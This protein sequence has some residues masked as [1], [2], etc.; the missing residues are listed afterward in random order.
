L[1]KANIKL[2]TEFL[3]DPEIEVDPS[4]LKQVLI[5]LVQNAAESIGRDGSI[6]IRT[7]TLSRRP[8]SHGPAVALIEV[9]DTGKGIPP[10]AQKRLFDPFFT[11]KP[12]GTGLGLSIAARILEKHGGSLEYETELQRG[13]VFRLVLPLAS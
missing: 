3:E 1:T 7:R 11:T 4:Q 2:T 10:E 9:Q 13:T 12:S 5:N 6:T 8:R